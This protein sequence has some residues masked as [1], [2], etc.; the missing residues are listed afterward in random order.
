MNNYNHVLNA[1]I[2]D[3][4]MDLIVEKESSELSNVQQLLSTCSRII[5]GALESSPHQLKST[6][7][8]F[9]NR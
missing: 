3:K 1:I 8:L 7:K 6:T 9:I 2:D 4:L 5:I